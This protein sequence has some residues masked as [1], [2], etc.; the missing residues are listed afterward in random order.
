MRP[1]FS[2]D[3]SQ[4]VRV[5]R[6]LVPAA[7][8]DAV[9]DDG[10]LAAILSRR[11]AAATLAEA[12]LL[13]YGA[14]GLAL[15][16]HGLAAKALL[17]DATTSRLPFTLRTVARLEYVDRACGLHRCEHAGAYLTTTESVLMELLRGKDHP[18]FKA[19]ST[20]LKETK[21]PDPLEPF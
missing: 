3:R 15:C 2:R 13:A 9:I 5:V 10:L 1:F 12:A 7:L 6:R 19:I 14:V 20:I 18:S 8:L 21:D 4:T 17:V 16:G 11:G